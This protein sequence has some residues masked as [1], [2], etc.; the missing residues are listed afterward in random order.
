MSTTLDHCQELMDRLG[1]SIDESVVRNRD[2]ST[3][4]QV[5]AKRHGHVIFV[6]APTRTG[7]WKSACRQI[8]RTEQSSTAA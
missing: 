2:G 6:W 4:W 5:S 7:A 3:S 8:G 1:W